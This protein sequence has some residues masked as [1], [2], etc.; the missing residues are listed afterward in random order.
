D[1]SFWSCLFC[2]TFPPHRCLLV[3]SVLVSFPV[4]QVAGVDGDRGFDFQLGHF[5]PIIENTEKLLRLLIFSQAAKER[6]LEG[7]KNYM[8]N[9]LKS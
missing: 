9:K 7:D 8:R 2:L 5:H 6:S 3:S 1:M 4:S